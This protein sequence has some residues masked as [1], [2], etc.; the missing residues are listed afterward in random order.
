[1]ATNK[2]DGFNVYYLLDKLTNKIIYIGSTTLELKRRFQFHCNDK[3]SRK[4]TLYINE[5]GKDNV[6]ISL[7]EKCENKE[8]MLEREEYWTH[9]YKD[10]YNLLNIDFAH[11]HSE[12]SKK[13]IGNSRIYP[14]GK[15]VWN[16]GVPR[17]NYTKQKISLA[18]KGKFI[19]EKN[20]MFGVHLTGKLNVNSKPVKLINTGEIFDCINEASKVYGVHPSGIS[21]N[22]RGERNFAGKLNGE[23]L[24]WEFVK[25]EKECDLL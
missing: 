2:K 10:K 19:G 5:V 15:D 1:M 3:T 6:S 8:K 20:P 9:Y 12:E 4:V 22:C 18:L 16:Y 25:K 17:S 11:K 24:V 23:K 13:H 14:R 7:I 21:A